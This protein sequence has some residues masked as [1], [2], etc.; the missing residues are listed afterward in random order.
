MITHPIIRFSVSAPKMALLLIYVNVY[1][2]MKKQ[3]DHQKV[4][5]FIF[6]P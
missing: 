1:V 4:R 2:Q 3:D 6:S 5:H